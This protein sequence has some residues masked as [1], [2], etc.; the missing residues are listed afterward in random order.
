M[1]TIGPPGSG[2][3]AWEE[4]VVCGLLGTGRRPLPAAAGLVAGLAGG[5]PEHTLLGLAA[6]LAVSRDAGRRPV[7]APHPPP[8]PCPPDIMP[9]ARREA[10]ER[11]RDLLTYG[12]PLLVGEWL[13]LAAAAGRRAPEELL[14]ALLGTGRPG[15][16]PVLGERG[17]WLA[18]RNPG[19]SWVRELEDP[20]AA[21]PALDPPTRQRVFSHLRAHD[22]QRARALLAGSWPRLPAGERA[23][24]LPL[25]AAGLSAAD[26]PLLERARHDRRAGVR[27]S[28]AQLL[29]SLPASQ[30]AGEAAVVAARSVEDHPDGLTV[31]LP[32]GPEDIA[33]VPAPRPPRGRG[34]GAW[35][36]QQAVAHAPLRV[37]MAGGLAPRQL[38][39]L[40]Q[41]SGHA[42]PL[43]LG[44]ATAAAR[45]RDAAW[46]AALLDAGAD[47]QALLPV[48]P[49][50][51]AAGRVLV[52]LRE[53]GLNAES[54][55][56]LEALAGEWPEAVSRAVLAVLPAAG[57]ARAAQV[58]IAMHMD[59]ALADEAADSVPGF[60]FATL[61]DFLTARRDMREEFT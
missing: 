26:E 30:F 40:A 13:A 22:P 36:L 41:E 54:F 52:R 3:V 16:L 8:P 48:L 20:E 25:L 12:H 29:S 18:A 38:I 34:R 32:G 35:L 46:A 10:G 57:L 50:W 14:P 23:A 2:S 56:L 5:D 31:T 17:R 27:A 49:R 6:A 44:W 53:D 42:G 9:L 60:R 28:A 1:T 7:P 33:P 21:W 61:I 47:G 43:L 4:L 15:V 19:W 37:W 51:E 45:Q 58:T 11:L 39:R 24:L 55:A 59:P